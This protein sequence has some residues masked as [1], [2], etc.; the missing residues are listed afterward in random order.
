M[1]SGLS[2][3]LAFVFSIDSLILYGFPFNS[4]HLAEANLISRTILK[5][6]NPLFHLPLIVKRCTGVKLKPFLWL[7]ILVCAVVQNITKCFL[8]KIFFNAPFAITCITWK[9]KQ[10]MAWQH[11]H[12]WMNEINK[13]NNILKLTKHFI[14]WFSP[15]TLQWYP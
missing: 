10:T 14:V 7:Y 9:H 4:F 5:N 1:L 11:H 8:K 3:W 12:V 13:N 6:T 2:F 15:Q